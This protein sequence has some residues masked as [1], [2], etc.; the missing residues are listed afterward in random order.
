MHRSNVNWNFLRGGRGEQNKNLPWGEYGYFLELHNIMLCMVQMVILC[1]CVCVF[2]I[3]CLMCSSRKFPY[4]PCGSFF[5]FAPP[6]PKKFQFIFIHCSKNVA[7]KTPSSPWEFP[8]TLH[9]VGMDFFWNVLH[10]VIW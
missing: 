10:T 2:S 1:V 4:S 7:F 6:S 8:M 3:L 9:G 5:G